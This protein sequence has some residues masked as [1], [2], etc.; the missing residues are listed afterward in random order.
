M[1]DTLPKDPIILLSTINTA[2]RDEYASLDD[3]CDDKSFDKDEIIKALASVNYSYN[4][5]TNQ[6]K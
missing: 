1:R 4:Q 5:D 3:L 6:F 2:L